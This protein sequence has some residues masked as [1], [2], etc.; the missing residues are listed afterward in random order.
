MNPYRWCR[1]IYHQML[2]VSRPL[3]PGES[4]SIWFQILVRCRRLDVLLLIHSLR[5]NTFLGLR[6]HCS[7]GKY[8]WSVNESSW[9]S[10]L[11]MNRDIFAYSE[12]NLFKQSTSCQNQAGNSLVIKVLVL[13]S[14]AIP[15]PGGTLSHVDT[16]TFDVC[17]P[18][19]KRLTAQYFFLYL[20]KVQ[21]R[22]CFV[23][24]V[25]IHIRSLVQ[26]IS[27]PFSFCSSCF[28]SC[29]VCVS[30]S[31]TLTGCWWNNGVLGM[32]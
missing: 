4:V 15:P 12:S 1:L 16:V 32:L 7:W 9:I 10:S 8:F 17:F 22:S 29:C 30:L 26:N 5:K 25:G 27:R 24:N 20:F 6:N 21:M 3:N 23:R 13:K 31:Y 14:L 2:C 19:S 28:V 11:N 18:G